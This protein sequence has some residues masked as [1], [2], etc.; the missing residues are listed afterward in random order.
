ML[1]CPAD[2]TVSPKQGSETATVS[3]T[4]PSPLD[5]SGTPV[6]IIQTLQSPVTL[7]SGTYAVNILA[8]DSSLNL[9]S[10]T[11]NINVKGK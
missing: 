4:A 10:C 9:A 5:N 7:G 3:W 6:T 1:T 8:F 11:F 2:I